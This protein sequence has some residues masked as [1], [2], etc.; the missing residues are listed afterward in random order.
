MATTATDVQ[1]DPFLEAEKLDRKVGLFGLLWASEG[2]I[3][4]S[5]WLFGPLFAA[6]VAGPSAIFG[7]LIASVIILIL[8]LVHAEL[9]G[10]FPVAGGTSRFPHYSFGSFAGATFGWFSYFQAMVVAPIEVLAVFQYLSSADWAHGLF[11]ASKDTL[12]GAGLIWAAVLLVIFLLVNLVGI[13]WLAHTNSSITT[14][15]VLLPIFAIIVLMGWKFHSGNFSAAGG[16]FISGKQG[17]FKA[18]VE[19]FPVGVIFALLG[20]E[21]AVQI[22]GESANPKRDIPRAVIGSVLIGAVIYVMAQVAFIGAL[23]P[24]L[25]ASEKTWANVASNPA[26][27]SGPFYTVAKLAALGWLAWLLRFDAVVSPGGTGLIYLTSAS[28]I[29]FGL[30]KNGMIPSAFE[31][32]RVRK[33]PWVGLIVSAAIGYLFILPFPSWSK[34]VGIVSL[35]SVMMYA[36]APLALGALRQQKGNL[37]RTYSLPFAGF[38][39]PFAFFLANCV[40]YY[41]GWQTYTVVMFILLVGYLLMGISGLLHANANQPKLDMMA[42]VWIIPYLVGMGV[43]SFLGSFGHGPMFDGLYGFQHIWRGGNGHLGIGWDNLV[44]LI[45]SFAVYYFAL[46]L[47]LPEDKVD[48]YVKDVYPPSMAGH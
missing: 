27:V 2:S 24:S 36:A 25:I 38:L 37:P 43:I 33:V 41:T 12:T 4:G 32:T 31:D 34:M 20:F 3:I 44:L 18:I 19:T 10:I 8:A 46:Y 26:L 14:W 42:A 29:S 5:G 6:G 13:R 30:S 9:G 7:W 40:I 39:A 23:S 48:E 11:N 17:G 35:I 22:A 21:Q 16:F 28:R 15:K 47:K 45:F 1:Q